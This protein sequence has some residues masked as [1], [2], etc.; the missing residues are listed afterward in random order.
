MLFGPRR[1]AIHRLR[2]L[3]A[4]AIIG[5]SC[6]AADEPSPLPDLSGVTRVVVFPFGESFYEFRRPADSVR[7]AM[8][9]EALRQFPTG[10]TA[11]NDAPPHPNLGVAFMRDSTIV[12]TL[13]IGPEFIA[14]FSRR[15]RLARRV[16]RTEETHLRAL[17]DSGTVVGAISKERPTVPPKN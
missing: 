11:S 1:S 5:A 3:A 16:S 13:W 12:A 9:A 10:W 6:R 8:L 2:L 14:G 4:I 15:D 17:L 7:I